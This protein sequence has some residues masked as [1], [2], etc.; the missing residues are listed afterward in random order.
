MC[1]SLAF[2][3]DWSSLDHD[4]IDTL[5]SR[6]IDQ[7]VAFYCNQI[8]GLAGIERAGLVTDSD[9]VGAPL[10]CGDQRVTRA[11]AALRHHQLDLTIGERVRRHRAVRAESDF[12]AGA[13]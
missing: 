13:I 4:I 8:G 5:N 11:H 12:Y 1:A 6:R 10:G 3:R 7:R 2:H 9:E